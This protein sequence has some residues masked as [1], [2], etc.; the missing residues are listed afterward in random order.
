MYWLKILISLIGFCILFFLLKFVI[1]D[2]NNIKNAIIKYSNENLGGIVYTIMLIVFLAMTCLP[3]LTMKIDGLKQESNKFTRYILL[4]TG[5]IVIIC[6]ISIYNIKDTD[7]FEKIYDVMLWIMYITQIFVIGYSLSLSYTEDTTNEY[8]KYIKWIVIGI[9]FIACGYYYFTYKQPSTTNLNLT[10]I[11]T[12]VSKYIGVFV[13]LLMAY[14]LFPV[15]KTEERQLLDFSYNEGNINSRVLFVAYFFLLT[16]SLNILFNISIVKWIQ[17]F[18]TIVML[19]VIV[20]L[21]L[22]EK[23]TQYIDV[24]GGA[25]E[26]KF[27][28]NYIIL[29]IAFLFTFTCLYLVYPNLSI[30]N[31]YFYPITFALGGIIL[32]SLAFLLNSDDTIKKIVQ[33]KTIKNILKIVIIVLFIYFI[34][35]TTK[36]I[37]SK[38]NFTD[39]NNYSNSILHSVLIIG[40]FV[41]IYFLINKIKSVSPIFNVSALIAVLSIFFI[42]VNYIYGFFKSHNNTRTCP[43]NMEYWR[44]C[45]LTGLLFFILG[46]TFLHKQDSNSDQTGQSIKTQTIPIVL[47]VIF[48]ILGFYLGGYLYKIRETNQ[49][50]EDGVD[51]V[52]KENCQSFLDTTPKLTVVESIQTIIIIS[53]IVIIFFVMNILVTN[54]NEIELKDGLIKQLFVLFYLFLLFVF[55][56][57]VN[58]DIYYLTTLLNDIFSKN[59]FQSQNTHKWNDFLYIVT[60]FIILFSGLGLVEKV[61]L[62]SKLSGSL[63]P[64]TDVLKGIPVIGT[65][66]YIILAVFNIIMIIPCFVN[67]IY[68]NTYESIMKNPDKNITYIFLF[69]VILIL[70]YIFARKL[71]G[72][73]TNM[74]VL[75]N[76]PIWLNSETVISKNE[77]SGESTGVQKQDIPDTVSYHYGISFWFYIEAGMTNNTFLNILNY[78]NSPCVLYKPS[79]N[80]LIFTSQLNPDNIDLSYKRNNAVVKNTYGNEV[81][82]SYT[83]MNNNMHE[84]IEDRKIICSMTNVNLQKWNNVFINF[85]SGV[86][87]IFVNG[88]LVSSTDGNMIA[89][90]TSKIKVGNDNENTLIKM[91]NLCFYK[92][93]L[94]LDSIIHAYNSS[95]DSN[96]P[97]NIF[98]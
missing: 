19:I 59:Y 77:L 94:S 37:T 54:L 83:T 89:D 78:N 67:D 85:N 64:F 84:G 22:Y 57:I 18:L 60:L 70:L 53:I 72:K 49:N 27:G 73:L 87:D 29:F 62:S 80:N 11:Q 98:K 66:Y 7:S 96:P 34:L 38:I 32:L 30:K 21:S 36:T 48:T 8:L 56:K 61:A 55:L 52:Q 10:T 15:P 63:K 24:V 86:I 31:S 47:L 46:T 35:T 68:E 13:I 25:D 50:I 42:V 58:I 39:S 75:I 40:F 12:S 82:T 2:W 26:S 41:G 17:I 9:I 33:N 76:D 43:M 4:L 44:W 74:N 91:C 93:N 90:Y 81:I 6:G 95:K 65:L 69:E 97:I 51:E 3:L 14:K 28:N 5:V 23:L 71:R 45:E 16:D 88:N 20:I 1:T 92:E 79:M